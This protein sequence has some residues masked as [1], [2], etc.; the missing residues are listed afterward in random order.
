MPWVRCRCYMTRDELVARSGAR[1]GGAVILPC[2]KRR[3]RARARGAPARPLQESGGARGVGQGDAAGHLYAPATPDLILDEADDPLRL[4]D[5][6]PNPDPVL[7]TTS[8]DK[9][10]PVP[11]YVEY[12]DQARNS[13]CSPPVSTGSPA[14]QGLRHLSGRGEAPVRA[15]DRRGQRD[16][17]DSGRRLAGLRRQGQPRQPDPVDPDRADRRALIQLYNARDR[18]KFALYESRASA[19]SCAA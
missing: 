11:D 3:E 2:S 17:A 9:R 7:A 10:I 6:F 15:A 5:F 13:T 12:Q 8:N 4:P 1:K 14:R 18:V 16:P 19:T